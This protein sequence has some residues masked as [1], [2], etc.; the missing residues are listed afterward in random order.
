MWKRL[1]SANWFMLKKEWS[2]IFFLGRLINFSLQIFQKF[3][4]SKNHFMTS[5]LL[6]VSLVSSNHTKAPFIRGPMKGYGLFIILFRST[7]SLQYGHVCF[8]PTMHHP[9]MQNSW[10]LRGRETLRNSTY[11]LSMNNLARQSMAVGNIAQEK[12]SGW[13]NQQ[14]R[15]K[16]HYRIMGCDSNVLCAEKNKLHCTV[17]CVELYN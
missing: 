9:R 12:Q 1:I 2:I 6:S 3:H 13:W 5:P 4:Q 15:K 10:N 11:S 8:L 14:N 17:F 16:K 7:F